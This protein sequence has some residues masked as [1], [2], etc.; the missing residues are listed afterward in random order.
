VKLLIVVPRAQPGEAINYKYLFPLGLAYISAVLKQAK[1]EVDCF[2]ANHYEGTIDHLL[3]RM[4][5]RI[6]Y[7]YILTGGLSTSYNQIKMITDAVHKSDRGTGLILGGGLI[8]SEP[9]LMFSD[10]RPDYIVIGEGEK[11]I[12]EL[13]SCLEHKGDISQVAGI[14]YRDLDGTFRYAKTAMPVEDLDSL[15]YPDFEGFEFDK[16]LD[17]MQPSDQYF[18]DLFDQPR[19]YPI[20]CSR[21]CP[22]LCTFCFHPAGNKYRQ[23]SVDSIMAELAAMVKRYRINTIAI[24]DEL[25]SNNREWLYEFCRRFKEFSASLSWECR[26]SCQMRVD[27][28]DEEMLKKMRD[29]GCYMVSYGF[30]SYNPAVLKSMKK[31]INQQQIERAVESTLRN[32]I[33]IQGNFIFG[34]PAE[35]SGTAQ[36]TLDYW[37]KHNYAGIMLGFINPYPGSDIYQQCVRRG[38]IKDKLDFIANHIFDI[39]NM[40]ETMTEKEFE[41]LQIDIYEAELKYKIY[42]VPDSVERHKDGTGSFNVRCPHCRKVM[43][44]KNYPLAVRLYFYYMAYCRSC[45]RRFFMVSRIYKSVSM[46]IVLLFAVMPYRIK[47]LLYD[48]LQK[49]LKI[50]PLIRKYILK[51]V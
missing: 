25:F 51:Y 47:K 11:T 24:Y 31:H 3:G 29:A 34:D 33:S 17:R 48:L 4:L 21:S 30:E 12:C 38:I 16:Y 49:S 45:R 26:W 2:N 35:T 42:A 22:F 9:E 28:M 13:L 41:K 46:I 43:D 20:V 8:S 50:K 15:P 32:D 36:E 6:K 39:L 7:D 44:Y 40:S 18:Y 5:A 10:L 19:V 1:H 27:K 37:K 14:G 23:R